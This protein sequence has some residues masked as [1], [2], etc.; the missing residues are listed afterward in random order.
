ML[1][2]IILGAK[3]HKISKKKHDL[4]DFLSFLLDN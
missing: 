3:V 2:F 1:F 4:P